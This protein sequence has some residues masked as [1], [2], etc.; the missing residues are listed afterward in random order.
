MSTKVENPVTY[1]ATP[2]TEVTISDRDP[3][4]QIGLDVWMAN[5]IEHNDEV[6]WMD[7]I[8]GLPG[9]Y[10]GLSGRLTAHFG[11]PE[12]EDREHCGI[13]VE[14]D[15]SSGK[16][17]DTTLTFR[18]PRIEKIKKKDADACEQKC[19]AH[20]KNAADEFDDVVR[21]AAA[22]T[23]AELDTIKKA[24]AEQ[25]EAQRNLADLI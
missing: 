10:S 21:Q 11:L 15:G 12:C 24:K 3:D 23:N 1:E 16:A 14:I 20:H 25:A 17:A 7:G 9:E 18:C 6:E 4:V 19:L 13:S 2:V 5:I 8:A 22:D